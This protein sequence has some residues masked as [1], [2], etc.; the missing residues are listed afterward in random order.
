MDEG[1]VTL[2]RRQWRSKE[3][4]RSIV[5]VVV[6]VVMTMKNLERF[7]WTLDALQILERAAGGRGREE[8]VRLIGQAE[9]L[10][11]DRKRWPL[12]GEEGGG[13]GGGG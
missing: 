5:V 10:R 13:R 11:L 6:V 7:E 1:D 8:R 12:R 2:R 3:W 9:R 4:E